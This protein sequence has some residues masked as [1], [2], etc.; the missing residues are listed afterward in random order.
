MLVPARGHDRRVPVAHLLP[1]ATPT[2]MR[3]T[4]LV[5]IAGVA[6]CAG[7]GL[8][9]AAAA[10]EG[11]EVDTDSVFALVRVPKCINR[12]FVHSIDLR[13]LDTD[14]PRPF[15]LPGPT[16]PSMN[17]PGPTVCEV[18]GSWPSLRNGERRLWIRANIYPPQGKLRKV[19]LRAPIDPAGRLRRSTRDGVEVWTW[20][21]RVGRP[22]VDHPTPA[23]EG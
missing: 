6:A 22:C 13:A 20:I 5:F 11:P 12:D 3:W 23:E 2:A 14:A 9:R 10:A 16:Y 7:N 4:P 15:I 19:E 8:Q 17:G 21:C 1:D 18:E